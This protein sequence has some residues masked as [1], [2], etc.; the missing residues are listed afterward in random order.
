MLNLRFAASVFLVFAFPLITSAE[1]KSVSTSAVAIKN[2]EN[3]AVDLLID[4][5]PVDPDHLA[6]LRSA[7][8]DL[9]LLEPAAN[10]VWSNNKLSAVD[11]ASSV[12][13][14]EGANLKYTD[15]VILNPKGWHRSQVQAMG[16]DGVSHDYRLV[17]SLDLHQAMMRAALLRKL[18]YPVP[19]PKWYRKVTLQFSN[20]AERSLFT[21]TVSNQSLADHKRW[22]ISEDEK[23]N[24]IVLQDVM[25]EPSTITVPT[26]FYM[27][28]TS[29]THVRGRRVLR[30]LLVPFVLLDVPESVNEF[31]W[32]AAQISNENLIFTHKYADSFDETTY[33]DIRWM[34]DKIGRLSRQDFKEIVDAG[35]YPTD[36]AAVILEKTVARRNNLVFL[37]EIQNRV[38]EKKLPYNLK[39]T[40]GT[41][42]EGKVTQEH[43]DGYALRFT[44]GDPESPLQYDNIA[45][46]VKIEAMSGLVHQLAQMANAELEFFPMNKLLQQRSKDLF[47]GFVDY[48]NSKPTKP[49]VQPISTWGGPVGGGAINASR[50]VVTGSYFGDESSD[51]RVSLVDQISASARVGYFMGVDGIPKIIP[52]LGANLSVIRSYVHVRPIPSIQAASKKNWDELW[53]PGFM[54]GLGASL[55]VSTSDKADVQ[56]KEM[57]D[58]ITKFLDEL[59]ENE[60]FTITDTIALGENASLTVPLTTLL[61]IDPVSYAATISLGASANQ[62][63]LRR[64][65]FTRE[66]GQIK[67]YLQNIQS[68]TLG[69][70]FDANLWMNIM[71]Q[72]YSHKWGTAHTRAFHLNESPKEVKDLRKTV[73]AVKGILEG[74]NSE[75]LESNFNPYELDHKTKSEISDGKF[76]FWRWTNIEEWHRVKIRPPKDVEKGILDP[77]LYQRTLFSHRILERTG[78]NYYS[79]LGDILDGLVQGSTFWKPGILSGGGGS[80]PKD[81]FFGNARWSV[82]GTEAEVTKGKEGN[83]VTTV[84][85]FWAGWDLSKPDLFKIIDAIHARLAGLGLSLTIIDGDVFNDMRRLQLYEIRSTF[86]IYQSGM[87]KLRK[88][89]QVTG[90]ARGSFIQRASGWDSLSGLDKEIVEKTLV[91]MYGKKRFEDFCFS[92]KMAGG[93]ASG[94]AKQRS[95]RGVSYDCIMP[96]MMK[97]L[98]LRHAYPED[99]EEQVKWATRLTNQLEHNVDL[100][101][102]IT[103][104]G[105]ENLFYQVKISGFRTRDETGD[106]AEYKSSTIG[107]FNTKDKAGVFRDFVTDY[108][109][110]S[111]EMN[112]AYLSEGY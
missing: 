43:Y 17:I 58:G 21:A 70:T 78:K 110:M 64:T 87:E 40:T 2:K 8:K 29:K 22:M 112:A 96:W 44:H 13:P 10:D 27:A 89:L 101:K 19:S 106:T 24:R 20:E 3:A 104:L 93:E 102:L 107:T 69:V 36:I 49:Y 25:L 84:E 18:G 28:N 37:A 23:Q 50:S 74:N 99:H 46:F 26:A 54:K 39:V 91:P 68:Q 77:S 47:Q 48:I 97:V 90:G 63:V 103:F 57:S 67:I 100:A 31:S 16:S 80:N 72:S 79:F 55:A 33:D 42:D 4:G 94:E 34:V 11:G 71:R 1:S 12:F 92:E 56:Q 111:S 52:T 38:P 45:Q 105:K 30:G 60:T 32:E 15:T 6:D 5:K 41:V 98:E 86:I 59:K 82:I 53:I 65:T 81:S 7:G 88:L 109:I 108:Q 35:M 75:L 73:L 85:N 61:G 9:S 62:I 51:Y 66:N 14:P 76:L 95:Y 83:P